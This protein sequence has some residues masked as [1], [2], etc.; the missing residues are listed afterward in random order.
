MNAREIAK[1]HL[2]VDEGISRKVYR[3]TMGI[4]TGGIG[5]NLEQKGFQDNEIAL[6]FENDIN[7]AEADA[8]AVV[9]SFEDLSENRKAALLNMAFNLGRDRLAGFRGMRDAI[10]AGDFERAAA[11]MLDSLWSRQ[12]GNRAKRLAQMMREG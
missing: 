5:R 6:M 10:A 2:K 4:L 8:R 11:E 1:V 12:V 3:D 9:P 7:D